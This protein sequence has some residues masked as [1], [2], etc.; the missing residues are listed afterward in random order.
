MVN[1]DKGKVVRSL[2]DDVLPFLNHEKDMYC[3]REKRYFTKMEIAVQDAISLLKDQPKK[4][5][6]VFH[7]DECGFDSFDCSVCGM[8]F[9]T[10][11]KI[12]KRHISSFCPNCGADMRGDE[13]NA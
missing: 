3:E 13:Q 9:D 4:G 7:Q 6:W 12:F 8:W 2:S 10:D 5:H 11:N 1:I